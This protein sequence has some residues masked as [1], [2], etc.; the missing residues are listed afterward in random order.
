MAQFVLALD[1]ELDALKALVEGGEAALCDLSE[2]GETLL[3][4]A[5]SGGKQPPEPCPGRPAATQS[6]TARTPRRPPA[7][8]TPQTARVPPP[9]PPVPALSYLF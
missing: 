3:M 2:D 1:G 7:P 6:P 4:V 8:P 5:C 9:T